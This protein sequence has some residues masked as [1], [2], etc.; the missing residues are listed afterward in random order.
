M[1]LFV[2]QV[3]AGRQIYIVFPLIE[4]SETLSARAATKEYEK[5]KEK[6]FP[7]LRIG[8]MHGKLKPQEKK[9]R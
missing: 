3:Q 4:E 8:L 5:L 6:I 9:K 1:N 2:Q 7:D